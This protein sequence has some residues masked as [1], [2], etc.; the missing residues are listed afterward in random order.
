MLSV[1]RTTSICFAPRRRKCDAEKHTRRKRLR[2][3][4]RRRN[5][6]VSALGPHRQPQRPRATR[7]RQRR[8]AATSLSAP[9]ATGPPTR[10]PTNKGAPDDRGGCV[11]RPN[12]LLKHA[13]HQRLVRGRVESLSPPDLADIATRL[14]LRLQLLHFRSLAHARWKRAPTQRRHSP[15]LHQDRELERAGCMADPRMRP[16]GQPAFSQ[17]LRNSQNTVLLPKLFYMVP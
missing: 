14:P 2:G 11:D 10:N 4:A 17:K 15:C 1:P 8:A 3:S 12:V 9:V 7:R 16:C 6:C 13:V 5:R